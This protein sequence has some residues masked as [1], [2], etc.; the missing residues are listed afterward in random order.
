MAEITLEN[1]QHHTQEF[2]CQHS[3]EILYYGNLTSAMANK[4]TNSI[5]VSRKNYLQYFLKQF[6]NG[7]FC[8]FARD[9]T[10]VIH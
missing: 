4:M 7:I 5:I 3:L 10:A 9:H 1:L 8:F 6:Q 2:L